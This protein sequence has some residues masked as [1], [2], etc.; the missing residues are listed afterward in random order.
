MPGMTQFVMRKAQVVGATDQIHA[1]FQRCKAVS[2]V[3]TFAREHCQALTHGTIES[4][5]Q[6][7]V[8]DRSAL[9][10]LQQL[11]RLDRLGVCH[12]P[13]QA[14]FFGTHL[15]QALQALLLGHCSVF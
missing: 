7:G 3:T 9:R 6:S 13:R 8:P 1:G 2:S 4:L 14:R 12:V 5:D 10:L 15:D 11:V